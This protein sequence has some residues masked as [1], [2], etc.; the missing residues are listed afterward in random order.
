MASP[1]TEDEPDVAQMWFDIQTEFQKVSGRPFDPSHVLSVD[2]VMARA[3][4]KKDRSAKSSAKIQKAK[5][6]LSKTL[7]CIQTFGSMAAQ[8]ASMVR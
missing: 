7:Y 8:A 3:N 6:V 4:P 2:D 5:D 1:N